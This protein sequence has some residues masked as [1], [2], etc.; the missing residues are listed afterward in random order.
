M[1]KAPAILTAGYEGRVQDEFFDLLSAA[2]VAVLLD[3]RAVPIS[4]KPGFSKTMLAAGAQA[5]GIRYVHLQALGTP[6]AGRDA[7]RAGKAGEMAVI[8]AAHLR[9]EAAQAG[10]AAADAIVRAAPTCLL[11]FERDHAQC[12]RRIVAERL[13]AVTGQAIS[14]L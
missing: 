8:F 13:A 6:K 7:A 14:H 4:R 3:I 1:T 10:L 9:G 11:C 2:G 5:R 12:H